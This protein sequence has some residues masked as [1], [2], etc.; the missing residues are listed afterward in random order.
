MDLVIKKEKTE[1]I[2]MELV[3]LNKKC[4]CGRY[5]KYS[6]ELQKDAEKGQ[7]DAGN[8][9]ILDGWYCPVCHY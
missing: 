9:I 2:K 3:D 5:L 8:C 1:I 7:R 4:R 6:E